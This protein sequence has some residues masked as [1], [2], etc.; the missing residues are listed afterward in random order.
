MPDKDDALGA[1]HAPKPESGIDSFGLQY[2]VVSREPKI[3]EP[4]QMR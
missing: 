3:H 2:V 4:P 1:L